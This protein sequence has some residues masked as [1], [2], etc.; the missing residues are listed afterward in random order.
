MIQLQEDL[1]EHFEKNYILYDKHTDGINAAIPAPL[2]N[3]P[4][5]FRFAE[6][7]QV[8]VRCFSPIRIQADQKEE[9]YELVHQLND[10]LEIPRYGIDSRS[11]LAYCSLILDTEEWSSGEDRIMNLIGL[12]LLL[13]D[14]LFQAMTKV[15]FGGQKVGKVI[16]ALEEEDRGGTKAPRVDPSNRIKGL[17]GGN[18]E[19]N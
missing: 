10:Q 7:G 17:M 18:P 16:K 8:G 4:T 1:V 2:G 11:D 3:V 13:V 15:M 6:E 5:K 14:R 9:I 12:S 19:L